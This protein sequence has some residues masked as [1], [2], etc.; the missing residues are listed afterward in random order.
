MFYSP[1]LHEELPPW[2][3][4]TIAEH[5]WKNS[6]ITRWLFPH[7][8]QLR[9]KVRV[10]SVAQ[11]TLCNP[12]DCSL[13]GSSVC[14]ISQARMLECRYFLI[15]GIFVTQGSKLHLLNWQMDSLPLGHLGHYYSSHNPK[16]TN[17]TFIF[18][19]MPQRYLIE[20]VMIFLI[21]PWKLT[22]FQWKKCDVGY[23]LRQNFPTLGHTRK[24]GGFVKTGMAVPHFPEFLI[25]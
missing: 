11:S 23:I 20:C 14:G 18:L 17:A 16:S 25:P 24:P 13:P 2:W 4:I 8:H 19:T 5:G 22:S 9:C 15:L 10:C 21:C 6:S 3:L 12:M 7:H 1:D